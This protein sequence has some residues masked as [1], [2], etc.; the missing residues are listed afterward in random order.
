MANYV[1]EQYAFEDGNCVKLPPADV[2]A[3]ATALRE[4]WQ[5]LQGSS[6]QLASPSGVSHSLA[7]FAQCAL[8]RAEAWTSE[9][10]PLRVSLDEPCRH[11]ARTHHMIVG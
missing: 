11:L 10:A 4:A 9:R 8:L 5:R 1:V 7:V 2:R 6:V 3:V